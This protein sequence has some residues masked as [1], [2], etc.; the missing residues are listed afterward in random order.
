MIRISRLRRLALWALLAAA[1]PAIARPAPTSTLPFGRCINMGNHL[2]PPREGAWGRAIADD[3]FAIIARAGFRTVRLP[4]RWSGH[5]DAAGTIDPAFLGR[6]QQVVHQARAAGLNVI[7]NDH[8]FDALMSAP[9]ANRA[10]LA[11]IWRQVAVAFAKEPRKH[12]WFEIENEP[13]DKL[14]NANLV[15]TLTPA[16]AAI[17]ESNPDRPVIVGGEFWSGIGSLATLE[18]PDDPYIVPTFHYYEPFDFT[19]QGATW[20]EPVRPLGRSYGSAED[21]ALLAG[22]VAKVR[23]YIART[24]KTPLL[25]EYGSIDKA[26][27]EQRV[28]YAAAVRSAFDAVGVATCSWAY[29][30]TFPLY[31]SAAKQWLPGMLEAVGAG[32]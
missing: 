23:A 5:L 27:V 15:A 11:Q 8:N 32:K 13:H 9:D 26:P 30:N 19:H 6:V 17:R 31:D 18:L 25:G 1:T 14:N 2:E 16:L 3:D 24:G 22:D 20:V 28:A 29:T 21:K 12:V 10:Q 4:V 7:I